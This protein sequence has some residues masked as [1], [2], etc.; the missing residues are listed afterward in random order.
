MSAARARGAGS[1]RIHP[2]QCQH[3]D[4]NINI[5]IQPRL[6]EICVEHTK[7]AAKTLAHTEKMNTRK[8]YRNRL[9]RMINWCKE[10]Y[11]AFCRDRN[12]YNQ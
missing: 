10:N 6:Y 5:A 12:V 9:T 11:P 2:G 7:E 4:G 3:G 8:D 1:G